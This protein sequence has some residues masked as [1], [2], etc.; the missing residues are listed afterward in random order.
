MVCTFFFVPAGFE[1]KKMVSATAESTSET[2]KMVSATAETT[3]ET[4][5][6]VS[7]TA[8]S[9]KSNIIPVSAPADTSKT[10]TMK[11]NGIKIGNLRN[12][13]HFQFM[14]FTLA[15]TRETGAAALRVEPQYNTLAAAV[16][17]EDEALKKIMKSALTA[18]IAAADRERDRVFRGMVDAVKSAHGH[19]NPTIAETARRLMIILDTYGNV[20]AKSH[21]EE[22]SALYNLCRDLVS[23]HAN[24]CEALGLMVWIVELQRLNR[25]VEGLLA[26]RA[27]EGAA[28]SSLVM[29]EARAEADAAFGA[30]AAMVSAQGLV[31]TVGT[32]TAAVA[33]F[34]G[35]VRR[36][37]ER[38]DMAENALLIRRG[39]AKAKA[40][41][42]KAEAEKAAAAAANGE[43]GSGG[44]EGGS[45]E[46]G[47]DPAPQPE[48][49]T[50]QP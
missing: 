28:R 49:E 17:R 42:K 14:Q 26:G 30:L 38:I 6:T 8:E 33:L 41:K 35:F 11:I 16:A 43:D 4:K 1:G 3:K 19:F 29:K 18:D 34:E 39:V 48:P 23:R 2:K 27:D 13:E 5:N 44:G 25:V 15:L 46:G 50:P 45:G 47:G 22:T 36:L 10:T 7:A 37:N 9:I 20:A 32:D 12:D 24:E 40:A 21:I 31:A